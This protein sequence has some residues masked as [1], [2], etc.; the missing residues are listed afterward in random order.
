[1]PRAYERTRVVKRLAATQPGAIKLARRYGDALV[2]VRYRHD[3]DGHHRYTTVELVV[4]KVP[5][6]HRAIEI[7]AVQIRTDETTLHSQAR[8]YGA[9][10]DSKARLWY[11]SRG[12]AKKL[13][14]LNRL[15]KN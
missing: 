8:K 9:K 14:L 12:T 4:E 13:G 7:V 10:W 2:C 1:M 6:V 11:M 15:V 3:P 5:I